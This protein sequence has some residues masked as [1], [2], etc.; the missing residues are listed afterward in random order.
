MR[1]RTRLHSR[2]GIRVRWQVEAP[3]VGPTPSLETVQQSRSILFELQRAGPQV[4]EVEQSVACGQIDQILSP[5]LKMHARWIASSGSSL[6][7]AIKPQPDTTVP[8]RNRPQRVPSISARCSRADCWAPATLHSMQGSCPMTHRPGV[9][10]GNLEVAEGDS[11]T[12]PDGRHRSASQHWPG[13]RARKPAQTVAAPGVTPLDSRRFERESPTRESP[14]RESPTRESPTRESPTPTVR[15]TQLPTHTTPP[16][17]ARPNGP[18]GR[19]GP[20]G[21]P[22]RRARHRLADHHH[23]GRA[24]R[25]RR[26]RRRRDNQPGWHRDRPA[27]GSNRFRR[28]RHHQ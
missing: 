18:N 27:R 17:H 9:A 16:P 23:H 13:P 2:C 3:A 19:T 11:N 8:G 26:I 1:A 28:L 15:E 22:I 14:T 4:F 21:I 25:H 10:P 12:A 7:L 6:H 24:A 5:S 20:A